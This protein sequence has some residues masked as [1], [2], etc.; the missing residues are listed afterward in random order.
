VGVSRVI[1]CIGGWPFVFIVSGCVGVGS[2]GVGSVEFGD[3]RDAC[4]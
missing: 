1:G 3:L 2:V 4:S